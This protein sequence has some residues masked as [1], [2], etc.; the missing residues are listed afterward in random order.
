ML[1]AAVGENPQD[2]A[3]RLH[4]A[5]LLLDESQSTQALDHLAVILREK[6]MMLKRLGWLHALPVQQGKLKGRTR[7]KECLRH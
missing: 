5:S 1:V 6:P 2:L 7:I 3:L 4:L